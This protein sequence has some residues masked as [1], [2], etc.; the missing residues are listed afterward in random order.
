[1]R[2]LW[3]CRVRRLVDE[4]LAFW[5]CVQLKTGP[6]GETPARKVVLLAL[7]VLALVLRRLMT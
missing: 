5:Q 4:D 3:A 6:M 2:L 1:M 7:R